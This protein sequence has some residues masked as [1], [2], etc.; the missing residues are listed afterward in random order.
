MKT[1]LRFLL[2]MVALL[3]TVATADAQQTADSRVADLVRAGKIRF[4]LFLPGYAKDPVTGE[5]RGVGTGAVTVQLARA[6]AA[7]LGVE[8]QLVGFPA[9]PAVVECLKAGACDV[10]YMGIEPS[11]VAEVGFSLPFMQ[12]DF[13]YLVPAGSTIRSAADVDKP[14][15]RIAVVRNHASTLALSRILKYAEPVGAEIPDTAF[16]LLRAGHADTWASPRYSLL[17]YSAQLP[18]SRVLEDRYGANLIAI[19]VPKGQAG[20]LAYISEFIEEAKASGLVQRAID[21]AGLLGYQ[22]VSPGN[23]NAQN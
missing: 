9:P 4:A 2:L 12:Q 7:R 16:E 17:E 21:R 11:R 3:A 14:G 1:S 10:A 23:P 22:V 15:V 19:A 6:L 18:G 5:L 20:R 8:V 13:T